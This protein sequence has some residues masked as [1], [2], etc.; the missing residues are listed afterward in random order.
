MTVCSELVPFIDNGKSCKY[1][2]I[3][4][5]ELHANS[6]PNPTLN[7]LAIVNI[8]LNIVAACRA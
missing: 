7:V 6:N 4:T 8:Q 5:N 3:T 2:Y 1:V